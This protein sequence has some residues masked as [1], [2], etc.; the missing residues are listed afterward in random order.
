MIHLE[1]ILVPLDLSEM[2]LESL[3]YAVPLARQFG[4]KITLLHVVE[5]PAYAPE[6]PCSAPLAAEHCA[7]VVHQLE[8]LSEERIPDEVEAAIAVRHN[9]VFDGIIEVAWETRAGLIIITTHG[10][11][12]LKHLLA[13]STAEN[14]VRQAPCPVLVVRKCEHGG[15][16]EMRA[17]A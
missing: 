17:P 6:L 1:N 10:H 5:P 11:T 7:A 16:S 13:G 15:G 8:T 14:V 4:A 3:E 9:F 12:G 2:S